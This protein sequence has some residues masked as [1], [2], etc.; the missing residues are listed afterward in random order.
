MI[1]CIRHQPS[2]S[3]GIIEEVLESAGLPWRYLD[4]WRDEVDLA[5][6]DLSGV[7]VL[8]GEMNV[9]ELD[10]YPFLKSVRDLVTEAVDSELPVFGVCLGAQ[11][12]TRALGAGVRRLPVPEIGFLPV[13]ATGT[14]ATDPVVAPFASDKSV[15]QWHEDTCDLPDGAELLLTSEPVRV[16]AFRV[17]ERAYG[18]Q[19]HFEV[20]EREIAAWCDETPDLESTWG[21]SKKDLLEEARH[22]LPAQQKAAREMTRRWLE[23]LD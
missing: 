14:G 5:V 20:R 22:Y 8:G 1:L 18:V 19:F 13:R 4:S 10:D 23:L 9:D 2:V 11:V 12:L 17:A 3:L 7:I 21:V 15:F 6:T 16:Q